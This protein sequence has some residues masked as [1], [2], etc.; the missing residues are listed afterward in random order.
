MQVSQSLSIEHIENFLLCPTPQAWLDRALDNIDIML[1]DHAHAEK[2]A[3]SSALSLLYRYPEETELLIFLSQLARE[4]LLHFEKVVA[5]M[6]KRGIRYT[7]L[8]PCRYA[9]G[10]HQMVAKA[11]PQRL[12]DT[13][14][15]AAIIEA[16]SCERFMRLI[17]L[18]DTELS[19]FYQSLVKSEARHFEN[20][21]HFALD[22][23]ADK[24]WVKER[25]QALLNKERLL[26]ESQEAL[27]RFHSGV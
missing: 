2:K 19:A 25:Q 21:L 16:R 10:L 24:E 22:K 9:G 5:I 17:P 26:I 27:F 3:A 7:H 14:I 15:V 8:S 18:L 6:A 1:I 11:E 20:Y 23:A 13:L 12:I 4:E